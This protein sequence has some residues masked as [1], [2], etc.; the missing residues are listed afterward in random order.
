MTFMITM[1]KIQTSNI[2]A[3]I[4]QPN[5]SFNRPTSRSKGTDNLRLAKNG[6]RDIT[7]HIGKTV[8]SNNNI[9]LAQK[10]HCNKTITT[11]VIL[12]AKFSLDMIDYS[13]N[14]KKEKIK[15]Y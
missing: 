10:K 11:Y 7:L 12:D 8:C 9:K 14:N 13:S 5:Q 6:S 15:R 3:I 2:H 1:R 4:N